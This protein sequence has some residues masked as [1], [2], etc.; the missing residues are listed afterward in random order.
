MVSRFFQRF[1]RG[2]VGELV[3]VD[4]DEVSAAQQ[5]AYDGRANESASPCQQ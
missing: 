3:D 4:D 5:Q 1:L 2:G